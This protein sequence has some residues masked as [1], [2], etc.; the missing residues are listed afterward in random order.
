MDALNVCGHSLEFMLLA[1]RS[2]MPVHKLKC[3]EQEVNYELSPT[4]IK[5]AHSRSPFKALKILCFDKYR[6]KL[7]KLSEKT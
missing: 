2:K 3:R 7:K 1:R 4:I 6:S 5:Y